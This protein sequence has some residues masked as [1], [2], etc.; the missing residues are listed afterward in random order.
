VKAR[1]RRGNNA[2]TMQWF[3]MAAAGKD[4]GVDMWK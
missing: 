3:A 1:T 2:N 4:C